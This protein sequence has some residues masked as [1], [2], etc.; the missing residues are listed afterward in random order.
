MAHERQRLIAKAALGLTLALGL[1]ESGVV[2]SAPK[3]QYVNHP[4]HIIWLTADDTTE[5]TNKQSKVKMS[6]GI[7][8]GGS[9]EDSP[10]PIEAVVLPSSSPLPLHH[11][12]A[13]NS[14]SPTRLRSRNVDELAILENE[15]AQVLAKMDEHPGWFNENLRIDVD[16]YYDIYKAA[17][18]KFGIDWYLIWINH[19]GETTASRDEEAFNGGTYPYYAGWQRYVGPNTQ[20]TDEFVDRAFAG[21][22]YLNSITSVRDKSDPREAAA[23]AAQLAPNIKKYL[24]DGPKQAVF[25]ALSIFTGD[26]GGRLTRKRTDQWEKFSKLFGTVLQ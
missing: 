11:S 9:S 4:D 14:P 7:S 26:G 22:E 13:I 23:C 15:K 24:A 16:K 19:E 2:S 6:T 18:D 8:N 17:G 5:R 12:Q 21:L 3:T 10:P 20:W 25:N 1:Q